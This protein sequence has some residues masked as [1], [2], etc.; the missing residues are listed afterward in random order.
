[1]SLSTLFS[2]PSVL[3]FYDLPPT[4]FDPL[5]DGRL[6]WSVQAYDSRGHMISSPSVGFTPAQPAEL[7]PQALLALVDQKSCPTADSVFLV[8]TSM[9]PDLKLRTP[10][11]P[12]ICLCSAIALCLLRDLIRLQLFDWSVAAQYNWRQNGKHGRLAIRYV[13]SC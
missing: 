2:D 4:L 5:S 6:H 7:V 11:P 8:W 13:I 9:M 3:D 1:M 12:Q 10:S